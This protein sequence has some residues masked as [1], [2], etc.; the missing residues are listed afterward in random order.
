MRAN[1]Q[2]IL[3]ALALAVLACA[4]GTNSV[5]QERVWATYS[6]PRFGTTADYPADVFTVRNRP[7]DN[8]GGQGF[9]SADG[10]A[11]LLIYGSYNAENDTPASYLAKYVDLEGAVVSYRRVTTRFYIVSGKRGPSIF[12]DRCNFPPASDGVINCLSL[13]YP[14]RDKAAWDAIVTRLSASLRASQVIEPRR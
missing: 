14:A 12:Y 4:I 10:G 1:R 6:N 7:P 13:T 5:A 2:N 11:E 3:Q 8:G 9:R